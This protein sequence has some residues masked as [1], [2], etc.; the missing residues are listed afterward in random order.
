MAFS[1]ADL[2][3][4]QFPLAGVE[5]YTGSPKRMP[6]SSPFP[7]E[8]A[9]GALGMGGLIDALG[10]VTGIPEGAGF[11]M[12]DLFDNDRWE[13]VS[14]SEF[15]IPENPSR[16]EVRMTNRYIPREY[17]ADTS[18]MEDQAPN[19]TPYQPI[20]TM[21]AMP[22]APPSLQGRNP[23]VPTTRGYDRSA[24]FTVNPSPY[25]PLD[26]GPTGPASA[27]PRG[28][29]YDAI[30]GEYTQEQLDSRNSD[31]GP[32]V[33]PR[34]MG[35]E[36]EINPWDA[37]N[38]QR[39][40]VGRITAGNQPS[41]GG[42][43]FDRLGK[44]NGGLGNAD[45]T[46]VIKESEGST[47]NTQTTTIKYGSN[48]MPAAYMSKGSPIKPA[49]YQG[50]PGARLGPNWRG[51]VRYSPQRGFDPFGKNR[52][53]NGSGLGAL[54]PYL[55]RIGTGVAG[56]LFNSEALGGGMDTLTPESAVDE[57]LQ[58]QGMEEYNNSRENFEPYAPL[59]VIIDPIKEFYKRKLKDIDPYM[60][61]DFGGA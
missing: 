17:G 53:F 9:F 41:E 55:G 54:T 2:L 50:A 8:S 37:Y 60:Y 28:M 48:A 58:R 14:G 36:T 12:A 21:T 13:Q 31:Y 7:S 61:D 6:E 43:P 26:L 16:G 11:K 59:D 27:T 25:V 46:T 40:D 35:L 56:L 51:P 33:S 57:M 24:R 38:K 42:R 34:G 10:G 52:G 44:F 15:G 1:F 19:Q 20:D 29:G 30:D 3:K 18:I 4:R 5:A 32:A 22:Y 39:S 49:P 47:P 45:V 23:P